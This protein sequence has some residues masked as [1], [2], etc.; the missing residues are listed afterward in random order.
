MEIDDKNNQNGPSQDQKNSNIGTTVC[1][2]WLKTGGKCKYDKNCKFLHQ[3]DPERY[4]ECPHGINCTKQNMGCNLKHTRKPQKECHAY[5]AGYCPL[6]KNCKDLHVVK[7]LCLNYLLG[8]CPDGPNCKLFHLKTMITQGMDDLN[9]LAK[10][11]PSQ[12]QS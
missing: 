10:D 7:D 5:N 8:F 4:P 2:Y 1:Y 12:N 11:L 9:Y 6:G 3:D